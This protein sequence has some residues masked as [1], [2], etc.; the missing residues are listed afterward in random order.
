MALILPQEKELCTVL[1]P[2]GILS[3]K[4]DLHRTQASSERF[5]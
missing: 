4:A 3:S 2:R 1:K 5:A